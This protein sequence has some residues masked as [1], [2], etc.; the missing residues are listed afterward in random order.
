MPY[1]RKIFKQLAE[2][3]GLFGRLI[4]RRLNRVNQGM[5][6]LTLRL[7][8]LQHSDRILEIGFGGGALISEIQAHERFAHL[9]GIDISE[10]AVSQ[11]RKRFSKALASGSMDFRQAGRDGLP[12]DDAIFSKVSCVNVIY[13]WPDVTAMLWEIYRVL[14]PGGKLVLSYSEGSPDKV[15]RFPSESVETWLAALGFTE[16]RTSSGKD[17]ENG[18]YHATIATK[19]D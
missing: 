8:D 12:F 19:P 14:E 13:F 4:L 6:D 17:R 2:P 7:L 9:V 5:N 3:D 1:S 16:T 18:V 15:T 10:L 11:A